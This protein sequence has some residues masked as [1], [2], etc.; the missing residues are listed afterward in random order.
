MTYATCLE[1][2]SPLIILYIEFQ[3]LKK[4]DFLLKTEFKFFSTTKTNYIFVIACLVIYITT[5]LI[6]FSNTS[7]F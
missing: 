7:V 3:K 2:L 5:R 1:T 4:K 6:W